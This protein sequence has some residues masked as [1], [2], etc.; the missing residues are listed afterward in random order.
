MLEF[1]NGNKT[2][3]QAKVKMKPT[4]ITKK[5]WQLMQVERKWC[6]RFLNDNLKHKF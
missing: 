1:R 6:G 3:S 4:Y 2:N 5:K